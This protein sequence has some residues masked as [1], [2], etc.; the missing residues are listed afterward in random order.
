[1]H[2]PSTETIAG[3]QMSSETCLAATYDLKM[4]FALAKIVEDRHGSRNEVSCAKTLPTACDC[5]IEVG[6][7]SNAGSSIYTT[8]K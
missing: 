1:M 2:L 3:G 4:E 6:R 8:E 5:W 7:W